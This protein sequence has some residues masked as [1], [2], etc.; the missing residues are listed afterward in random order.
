[1]RS[2]TKIHNNLL[3]LNPH[4]FTLTLLHITHN[5]PLSPLYLIHVSHIKIPH[6]NQTHIHT[7]QNITTHPHPHPLILFTTTSYTQNT[8]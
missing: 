8:H 1:M 3:N 5:T 7:H 2:E 4:N 6:H